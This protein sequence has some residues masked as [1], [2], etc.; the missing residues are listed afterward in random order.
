MSL[1]GASIRRKEDPRLLQGNGRYLSDIKLH[2]MVH[3]VFVRSPHAHALIRG[4]DSSAAAADPRV[5]CVLTAD[6]LPAGLPP[7]PCIDAEETTKP[8]N[9]PILATG[10]VRFVGEPVALVVVEG[11]RYIAEDIAGLVDVDYEPLPAVSTAEAAVAPD[12][13]LVHFDSNVV[14]VLEY[15]VATLLPRWRPRPIPSASGSSP[16]VMR[17]RRWRPEE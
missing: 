12:A 16:S 8:F 14:D 3:A 2:G 7:L 5:V 1:F 10:K 4:V 6:D 17:A 9:Q 11:D 15:S 13:P